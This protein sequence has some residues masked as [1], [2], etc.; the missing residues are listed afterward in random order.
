[1]IND[2]NVSDKEDRNS[3]RLIFCFYN[4]LFTYQCI[5]CETKIFEISMLYSIS[6]FL[7]QFYTICFQMY[8]FIEFKIRKKNFKY[9]P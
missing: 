9:L 1:M 5:Q 4:R 2:M 8:E 6:L 7:I 3:K